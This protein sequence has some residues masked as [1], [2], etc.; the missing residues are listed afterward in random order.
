MWPF[1]NINLQLHL[2][3]RRP[4]SISP[5]QPYSEV[6]PFLGECNFNV[7]TCD[8]SN[9]DTVDDFDW[10]LARGSH[11]AVTGPAHDQGAAEHG[12]S[13]GHHATWSQS[14]FLKRHTWAT[15]Q[16]QQ[17]VLLLPV[18]TCSRCCCM[19]NSWLALQE[20]LPSSTLQGLDDLGT[21]HCWCSLLRSH[22]AKV[23]SASSSGLAST[24]VAWETWGN[25][26][27]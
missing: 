20:R 7:D 10:G 21:L 15:G 22:L 24:G 27:G 9:L 1:S 25:E 18:K 17:F 26:E 19:T 4:N 2:N 5:S 6:I 13:A 11:K 8:Y 14:N 23:L 16:D 3:E 12:H